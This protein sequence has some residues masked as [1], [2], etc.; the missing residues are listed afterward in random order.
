MARQ[1]KTVRLNGEKIY[2]YGN[3]QSRI[4]L[5]DYCPKCHL[6]YSVYL[7]HNEDGMDILRCNTCG[8]NKLAPIIKQKGEL[9]LYQ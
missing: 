5:P 1:Y 8:Y 2:V 4:A 3:W 9:C 7:S 6:R